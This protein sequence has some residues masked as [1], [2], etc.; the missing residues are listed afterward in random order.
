MA[1]DLQPRAII[2]AHRPIP[3]PYHYK[4]SCIF[5]KD[6]VSSDKSA[7]WLLWWTCRVG[8]SICSSMTKTK[9]DFKGTHTVSR[10][11]EIRPGTKE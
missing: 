7:S 3:R 9:F 10:K 2:A 6:N 5:F 4:K 8:F 1:L 11:T